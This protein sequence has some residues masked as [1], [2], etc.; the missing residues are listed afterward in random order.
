MYFERER[1]T[2]LKFCELD[3]VQFDRKIQTFVEK[4][5]LLLSTHVKLHA[6]VPG[7]GLFLL[8][9]YMTSRPR[10]IMAESASYLL[11]AKENK[12][13]DSQ[14]VISGQLR[15]RISRGMESETE[16]RVRGD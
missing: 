15:K 2:K 10:K 8:S 16:A 9:H 3:I 4:C 12:H 7:K 1:K 5:C 13:I 6:A 14:Q 11:E